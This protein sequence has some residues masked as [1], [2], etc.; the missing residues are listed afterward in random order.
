MLLQLLKDVG[1]ARIPRWVIDHMPWVASGSR[2]DKRAQYRVRL[3]DDLAIAT[4]VHLPSGRVAPGRVLD[5]SARGARIRFKRRDCPQLDVGLSVEIRFFQAGVSKHLTAR[6]LVH[7]RSEEDGD[8]VFGFRFEDVEEFYPQLTPKLWE[9]FNRRVAYRARPEEKLEV[10]VECGEHHFR[11]PLFDLAAMG[12]GL[13]VPPEL[14]SRL[15]DF[16]TLR[17]TLELPGV[18]SPAAVE[19]DIVHRTPFGLSHRHGIAFAPERT[20]VFLDQQARILEWVLERE[21][22][23]H[24]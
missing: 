4:E 5:T 9:L 19:G 20:A 22:R 3:K 16:E 1:L 15:Q 13:E 23:Q 17:A 2:L 18:G 14:A 11:V 8:R 12:M 6:A 21:A 10:D 24:S 7:N